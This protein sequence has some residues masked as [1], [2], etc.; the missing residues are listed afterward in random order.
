M[1]SP[2]LGSLH[3]WELGEMRVSAL[4]LAYAGHLLRPQC[5]LVVTALGFSCEQT[6]GLTKSPL[7]AHPVSLI[8][9]SAPG[10]L[11]CALPRKQLEFLAQDCQVVVSLSNWGS[12]L[13]TGG[14]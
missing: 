3:G 7:S 4:A 10:F 11:I 6:L 12:D 1:L 9:P 2:T 5:H 13:S 14:C 8:C